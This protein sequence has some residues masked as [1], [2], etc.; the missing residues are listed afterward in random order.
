M[1]AVVIIALVAL[2]AAS[3]RTSSALPYSASSPVVS[4]MESNFEAKVKTAGFC[5]VEF[6]AP[7]CG[8]CKSLSPEYEKFAKAMKGMLCVA[9]VDADE[10]KSLAGKYGIKGFPTIKLM[11][12]DDGKIKSTDYQGGRTAKDMTQFLF[13]K[14]KAYA[15]KR[16]GEKAGGSGGKPSGG[17]GGGGGGAT[18][19]FYSGTDVVVLN[20]GNFADEVTNSNDIALV[21]FYAPWCGHCKNLKPVWIDAALQ[22]K[23]KVKIAAIDCTTNQAVCGEY[24]VQGYPTIKFFGKNKKRPEDYSGGRDSGSIVQFAMGHWSKASPAPEVRELIDEHVFEKECIGDKAEGTPAKQ[25]CFI[26][27]LPDI[28]DSK[29]SGRNAYIT[30]M[31]KLAE[32]Y[33]GSSFSYLWASATQQ[34]DL[35]ANFGVG[36]F[37]YPALVAFKPSNNKFSVAKSAF[38]LAHVQEF[39]ERIRRGGESVLSLNGELSSIKATTPWDGKDA[40][41]EEVEEFSLEDL[42][43]ER[44]L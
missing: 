41:V 14:A 23:G 44:E 15:L 32:Q 39:I 2:V 10:H 31:K 5:L 24:N 11:Y 1:K 26:A 25:L 22:L 8:H 42:F 13:D 37:G 43:D 30:I 9:A 20:D 36:G 34:P 7:W 38:E 29:A 19:S 4:L 40:A 33:K 6:Y 35:E 18:D 12:V 21:E 16:M 3:L 27:F 17:S 28:L